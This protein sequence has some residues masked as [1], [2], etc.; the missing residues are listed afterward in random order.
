MK[1]SKF[2]ESQIVG[3]LKEVEL[4]AKVGETCQ[5]SAPPA[6][7]LDKR[8]TQ[9]SGMTVSHLP[10]RREPAV[11]APPSSSACMP[12]RPHAPCPEG[13]CRPTACPR[14]G[15]MR[16]KRLTDRPAQPPALPA[17][18]PPM[19]AGVRRRRP[20]GLPVHRTLH[21]HLHGMALACCMPAPVIRTSPGARPC[22]GGCTVSST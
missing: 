12:P 17:T 13:R 4:G 20:P 15:R 6:N 5:K 9:Y 8:K 14:V 18:P 19:T 11:R 7:L 10:Q 3:I 16:F 22:C 21:G 1:K 2:S